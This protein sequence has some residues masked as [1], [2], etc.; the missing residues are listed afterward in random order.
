MERLSRMGAGKAATE[1]WHGRA[2]E[3]GHPKLLQ[4]ANFKKVEDQ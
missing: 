3:R 2:I 4:Y 1:R